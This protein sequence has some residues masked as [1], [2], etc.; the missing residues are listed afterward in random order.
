MTL[1]E[2]YIISISTYG[3]TS[4]FTLQEWFEARDMVKTNP[5][6]AKRVAEAEI[7]KG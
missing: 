2:A 6:V 5:S 4:F 7:R 3:P 1:K